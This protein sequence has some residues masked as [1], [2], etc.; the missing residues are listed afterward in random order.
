MRAAPLILA[1]RFLRPSFANHYDIS[2]SP[3]EQKRNPGTN[4]ELESRF[5]D[6]ASLIRATNNKRKRNADRRVSTV[7]THTAR[8]A[9]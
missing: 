7:R 3:D 9:H 5:P 4:N 8:G 2:S 1:A 6:G